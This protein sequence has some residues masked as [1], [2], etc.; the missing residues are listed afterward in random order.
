MFISRFEF[1]DRVQK[2]LAPALTNIY[3][4]L[5]FFE[6]HGRLPLL[7]ILHRKLASVTKSRAVP[8][9]MTRSC[10]GGGQGRGSPLHVNILRPPPRL[11][12]PHRKTC[13]A[14]ASCLGGG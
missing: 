5:I 4:Y 3:F 11:R 9:S 12:A 10:L 2:K 1:P 6:R 8:L 7:P 14:G 13:L